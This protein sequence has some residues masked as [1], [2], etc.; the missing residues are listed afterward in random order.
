MF[1]IGQALVEDDVGKAS[2][3]CDL[4]ACKGA[5]CCL[6]GG[7]GAPLEDC[8]VGEIRRAFPVVRGYLPDE[9]LR[10]IDDRG[11]VEGIPGD[12]T[13]PCVGNRECVYV[14]LD[15]DVAKCSFERAYLEGKISWRKPIS[16][17]LFPIRVRRFGEDF[18]RYEQ[19]DECAPGRARGENERIRLRHFL[20]V[21]L[22]R[23]FG[24][25]WYESFLGESTKRDDHAEHR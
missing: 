25:P 11:L 5:C 21:P 14:Y 23:R 10:V 8:E 4:D 6:E 3:C 1:V 22:V 20:K 16:C 19:I 2:F 9:S 7:R 24:E 18:V 17:H 13:T 12:Y 15:G